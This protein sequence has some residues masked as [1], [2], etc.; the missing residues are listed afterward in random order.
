MKLDAKI[1]PL[2]ANPIY[3]AVAQTINQLATRRDGLQARVLELGK[4]LAS[5]V[6]PAALSFFDLAQRALSGSKPVDNDSMRAEHLTLRQEVEA[7][8]AA[9][10]DG[11]AELQRAAATAS[12]ETL[13]ALRPQHRAIARRAVDALAAFAAA[14]EQESGML[15][16]ASRLG[17]ALTPPEVVLAPF[18]D[19]MFEADSQ[20]QRHLKSLQ[21]YAA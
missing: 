19:D 9:I 17:Y 11:R 1:P 15:A 7:I 12:A 14:A 2:S 5:P 20:F 10:R 16:E 13:A 8:D 4:I 21:R 6:E 3:A 18:V